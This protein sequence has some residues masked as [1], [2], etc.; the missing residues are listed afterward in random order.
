MSKF[1]DTAPHV[2]EYASVIQWLRMIPLGDPAS[3]KNFLSEKEFDELIDRCLQDI[4]QGFAYIQHSGSTD[5]QVLFDIQTYHAEPVLHWGVG[6]IMLV[7]AFTGLRRQS[8]VRLTI[9]DIAQIGPHVFALSW[10]HGKPNRQLIAVIPALVAEYLQ[11]YIRTTEPIRA[12]LGTRQVF[13]ARNHLQRWDLMTD[14]RLDRACKLF[15]SRHALTHNGAPFSLGSTL[16]R[17][18]YATRALYELPNVAAIQAQLGHGSAYT[19]LG[20]IQHD[21]FEHP[22]QVD[23]AL[24]AFGRKVLARWHKPLLLNDL[25]DAERRALLTTRVVHEQDV[26]MCRHTCC[27]KLDEA[28]LPPCSLCEHLVS[29]PE[30]LAAWEHEKALREQQLQRLARIPGAEL[31]LAQMKG[32]YD[33]F[34]ANYQFIQE[35]SR[36]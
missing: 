25:P 36:M 12:R 13:L 21:R 27:V 31:I 4:L 19:T 8:V 2:V 16:L 14:S 20:Y 22:D 15:A 29:G 35:R 9:E 26:G 7:M 1:T 10:Q 33:R 11:H 5:G 17:R 32:L 24:D 3:D 6:L 28:H 18:T 23:S 34:L 30:Y